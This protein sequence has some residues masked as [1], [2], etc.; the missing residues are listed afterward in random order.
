[1]TCGDIKQS[2][3]LFEVKQMLASFK[4]M[5]ETFASKV[6]ENSFFWSN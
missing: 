5:A 4:R 6:M 1:M 2:F 3:T